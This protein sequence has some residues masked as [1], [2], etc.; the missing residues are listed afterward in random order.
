[1]R[2]VLNPNPTTPRSLHQYSVGHVNSP[3]QMKN[4]RHLT[5]ETKERSGIW[6]NSVPPTVGLSTMHTSLALLHFYR[7]QTRTT[8]SNISCPALKVSVPQGERHQMVPGTPPLETNAPAP[9]Q[10]YQ[11]TASREY[12]WGG[13]WT[14]KCRFR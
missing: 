1:M 3:C 2:S 8:P 7:C 11:Y 14:W 13:S 4:Y 5:I 12:F 9:A 6:L 10:N